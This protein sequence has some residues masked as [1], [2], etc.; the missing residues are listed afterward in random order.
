MNI[1]RF[2]PATNMVHYAGVEFKPHL[3]EDFETYQMYHYK[4]G[5]NGGIQIYKYIPCEVKNDITISCWIGDYLV[6]GGRGCTLESEKFD[7]LVEFGED[8]RLA[9][10]IG[11]MAVALVA[12]LLVWLYKHDLLFR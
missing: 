12:W 3:I 8:N 2:S 7:S 5:I 10:I 9:L 1:I 4:L 11:F 6:A